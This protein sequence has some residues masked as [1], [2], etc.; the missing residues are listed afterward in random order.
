MGDSLL[1]EKRVNME[2]TTL[3]M[4][5]DLVKYVLPVIVMGLFMWYAFKKYTEAEKRRTDDMQD[6][7]K[8]SMPVRFQAYERIAL[9]LE[10]ISPLSLVCRVQPY[11]EG[12]ED[13]VR[14]LKDHIE[15]EYEY[16]LSQQVYLS[17][18]AWQMVKAARIASECLIDDAVR[19][20]GATSVNQVKEAVIQ[21]CKTRPVPSEEALSY[22]KKEIR[23]IF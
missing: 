13:Y 19:E 8:V 18:A 6:M 7:Q 10:R 2:N 16:N 15:Q 20:A 17:D 1:I 5:F 21:Y 14:L 12:V 22:I 4:V 3:S 11:S 9:L 23:A